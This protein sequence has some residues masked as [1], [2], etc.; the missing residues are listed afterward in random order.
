MEPSTTITQTQYQAP[1]QARSTRQNDKRWPRLPRR[2]VRPREIYTTNAQL[3]SNLPLSVRAKRVQEKAKT[4]ILFSF[5]FN[6][7]SGQSPAR[8]L[9]QKWS[10]DAM[11]LHARRGGYTSNIKRPEK[12]LFSRTS[13][14]SDSPRRS[15]YIL[16]NSRMCFTSQ[17]PG[18]A[19]V[20][21]T[22]NAIRI[23][24]ITTGTTVG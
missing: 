9:P 24:S 6:Q 3:A 4:E 11:Q 13:F 22:T 2:D 14:I 21:N 1:C 5:F 20:P 8:R 18:Y 23:A 10:S 19:A 15:W 12:R 16:M 7:S 17:A